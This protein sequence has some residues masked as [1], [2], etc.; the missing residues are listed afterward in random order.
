MVYADQD[1]EYVEICT[2]YQTQTEKAVLV[3]D[4]DDDIWIPKS[5]VEYGG[6]FDDLER[7]DTITIE[8]AK[9]FAEKEGMI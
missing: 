8:V 7:G 1:I 2:V 9:W 6:D 4:G 3:S 5:C